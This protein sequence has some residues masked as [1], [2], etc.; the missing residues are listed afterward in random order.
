M[1]RQRLSEKDTVTAYLVA[2]KKLICSLYDSGFHS[3]DGI[4]SRLCD[5]VPQCKGLY[6]ELYVSANDEKFFKTQIRKIK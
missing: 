1:K 6:A 5:K 4:F 2:N 3:I